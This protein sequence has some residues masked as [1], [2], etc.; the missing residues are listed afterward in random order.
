M[1]GLDLFPNNKKCDVISVVNQWSH[2]YFFSQRELCKWLHQ[3]IGVNHQPILFASTATKKSE[4]WFSDYLD[5]SPADNWAHITIHFGFVGCQKTVADAGVLLANMIPTHS[6]NSHF[7]N[8]ILYGSNSLVVIEEPIGSGETR[9]IVEDRLLIAAKCLTEKKEDA[10]SLSESA[11]CQFYCDLPGVEPLKEALLL[12]INKLEEILFKTMVNPASHIPVRA[13]LTPFPKCQPSSS[14]GN[15]SLMSSVIKNRITTAFT[16]CLHLLQ[17]PVIQKI[18]QMRP[19]LLHFVACLTQLSGAMTSISGRCKEDHRDSTYLNQIWEKYF[20]T[21]ALTEWLDQRRQGVAIIKKLLLDINL[22]Y[23]ANADLVTPPVGQTRKIFFLKTVKKK[24]PLMEQLRADFSQLKSL[25]WSTLEIVSS[26]EL[27]VKN[28]LQKLIA[29][30]TEADDGSP[31]QRVISSSSCHEDGHI[32]EGPSSNNSSEHFAMCK[33]QLLVKGNPCIYLL[34]PD[35][36]TVTTNEHRWYEF[37]VEAKKP[38]VHRTLIM[39][40]ASGCGKTT[41]VNSIIN[42]VL[43]VQWNDP[44]RFRIDPVN[45]QSVTAYT[46]HRVD[47]MA[48]SFSLTIIDTPGY[49]GNVGSDAK[50]TENIAEFFSHPNSLI[51]WDIVDAICLVAN[52]TEKLANPGQESFIEAVDSLFGPGD[53]GSKIHWFCTFANDLKKLP[54]VLET[55]PPSKIPTDVYYQF[56]NA[57]LYANKRD[58]KQGETEAHYTRDKTRWDS[59]GANF[60]LFFFQWILSKK[61]RVRK[62]ITNIVRTV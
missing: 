17:D 1:L 8:A 35:K 58:R 13:T 55:I 23:V 5:Y 46:I 57:V 24:D 47:G 37:G 7:V 48:I 4:Y 6:N 40:G 12:C 41:L 36:R 60:S 10:V 51:T 59:M 30:A 52:S 14:D 21:G 39:I 18:K 28:V 25:E 45:D 61:Q 32:T 54:T 56:D 33:T 11:F 19:Y 22:P 27:H 49:T 38:D 15:S 3:G 42:Y 53:Y 43:H 20:A 26:T 2:S 34:Q 9:E 44:F 31:V 62:S 29:F 50:T 16:D